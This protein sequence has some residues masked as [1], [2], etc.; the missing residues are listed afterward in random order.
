MVQR[1]CVLFFFL[2]SDFLNLFCLIL[3]NGSTDAAG[4]WLV[5][6]GC[7]CG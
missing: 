7:G 1:K 3:V 2:I 5:N 6:R 4:G